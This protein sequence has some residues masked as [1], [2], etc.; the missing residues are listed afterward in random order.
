MYSF[1]LP[2]S[3][4]HFNPL[5]H[6]SH[7]PPPLAVILFFLIFFYLIKK[8]KNWRNYKWQK[9]VFSFLASRHQISILYSDEHLYLEMP[10]IFTTSS[11]L[12]LTSSIVIVPAFLID[13]DSSRRRRS[14]RCRRCYRCTSIAQFVLI[15][16]NLFWFG[17]FLLSKTPMVVVVFLW[18]FGRWC[19]YQCARGDKRGDGNA[20]SFCCYFLLNKMDTW[21]NT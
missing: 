5:H 4:L 14:L 8:K 18:L 7:H 21:Q 9:T 13:P 12:H 2:L 3:S 1:I 6:F 11:L 16:L 19:V 17:G 10:P 15:V 20:V